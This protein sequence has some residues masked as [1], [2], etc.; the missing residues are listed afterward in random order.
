MNDESWC[1]WIGI[2]PIRIQILKLLFTIHVAVII[3]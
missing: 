1:K 3:L 2:F